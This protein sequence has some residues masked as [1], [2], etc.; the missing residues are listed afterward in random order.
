MARKLPVLLIILFVLSACHGAQSPSS[1]PSYSLRET[2]TARFGSLEMNKELIGTWD[3]VSTANGAASFCYDLE[4]RDDGTFLIPDTPYLTTREFAFTIPQPGVLR[5]S[6]GAFVEELAFELDGDQLK[7][8]FGDGYN[9]YQREGSPAPYGAYFTREARRVYIQF[10]GHLYPTNAGDFLV[11]TAQ[12]FHYFDGQASDFANEAQFALYPYYEGV[13]SPDGK[14]FAGGFNN[15]I[16]LDAATGIQLFSVPG[17]AQ[18]LKFSPDGKTFATTDEDGHSIIIRDVNTGKVVR[19]LDGG[20]SYGAGR[21]VLA[22]SPDGSLLAEAAD[23]NC[24]YLWDVLTGKLVT[25]FQAEKEDGQDA[26]GQGEAARYFFNP[27][28]SPDGK[29]VAVTSSNNTLTII[30]HRQGKIIAMLI[31]EFSGQRIAFSPNGKFLAVPC[32]KYCVCLYDLQSLQLVMRLETHASYEVR[33][34]VFSNNGQLLFAIARTTA[35]GSGATSKY[36]ATLW[37]IAPEHATGNLPQVGAVSMP[38]MPDPVGSS[39]QA[40]PTAISKCDGAPSQR[41]KVGEKG[42]VCTK[43]DPLRL[44]REPNFDADILASLKT[45]TVFE[46]IDGPTCAEEMFWWKVR[47]SNGQ[48]G[49]VAEGGDRVDPFFVCPVD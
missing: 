30:D 9:R 40:T 19:I 14:R 8:F 17:L 27:A 26:T 29:W 46:V 39:R 31:G 49:W 12:G 28:F 37:Q 38:E 25:F 2:L 21:E 32:Q 7:L 10:F 22:Y 4:F 16:M 33:E 35:A 6:P 44:R 13:L 45:G 11:T 20:G 47:L 34:V 18:M 43:S 36:M 41:L 24:L 23:D 42:K 3:I 1:T 5:L 15:I 48:V